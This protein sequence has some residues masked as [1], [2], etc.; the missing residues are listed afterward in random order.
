VPGEVG[1]LGVLGDRRAALRGDGRP[2][3][4]DDDEGG[5]AADAVEVAELLLL[6]AVRVVEGEPRLLAIVLLEGILALVGGDEDHLEALRLEALGVPLGELRSEAT[7]WRAPVCAEVQAQNLAVEGARGD[8]PLLADDLGSGQDLPEGPRLP[9][10]ALTRR[11]AAD[12]RAA[13]LRDHLPVGVQDDHGRDTLHLELAGK[14]LLALPIFVRKGL[15]G[16]LGK[17][18]LEGALVLV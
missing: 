10:E 15:P 6:L 11:I 16:H 3:R 5:D 7:A 18:L 4:I 1:P 8:L 17:V 9:G 14:F 12:R 13:V 2:V